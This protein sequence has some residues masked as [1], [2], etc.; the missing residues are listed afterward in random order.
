MASRAGE[1]SNVAPGESSFLLIIT[2][3][4]MF[5]P[6]DKVSSDSR[7]GSSSYAV[8]GLLQQLAAPPL[9]SESRFFALSFVATVRPV[10]TRTLLVTWTQM[11][12]ADVE[13][14]DTHFTLC[15]K[16]HASSY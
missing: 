2:F 5:T 10:A 1:W 6:F 9:M 4:E 11:F 7:P 14:H 16:L 3:H 13:K 15:M 12:G 8:S